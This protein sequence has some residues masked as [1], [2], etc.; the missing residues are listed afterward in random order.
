M[1]VNNNT[2]TLEMKPI[3][4]KKGVNLLSV[5]PLD[6]IFTPKPVVS[7]LSLSGI[8]GKAGVGKGSGMT[9]LNMRQNIEDAFNVSKAQAVCLLIDSP[10]GS[11]VQ[12]EMIASRIIELS[13]E[14]E[15]P[16][17]SFV[18][19]IA[20][21]GGYWLA[22]AG[23]EI[24]ASKSSIVGSIGVISAGFGFTDAIA[25]LGIERRV[26]SQGKNK[27]VLD[28]FKPTQKKDVEIINKL[29]KQV[30]QHFIDHVKT[31]RPGKLTQDDNILFNGDFWSGEIA[32]DFGLIDGIGNMYQVMKERFGPKVKFEYITAKES[33]LK[34]RLGLNR[35]QTDFSS[36]FAANLSEE[37]FQQ[38]DT[39]YDIQKYKLW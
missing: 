10:G 6:K 33:W 38:I 17:Y 12:S 8:I 7:V 37:L 2:A 20:A 19:D 21:S 5:W 36:E 29:Q 4:N 15:I 25:K 39:R 11:P 28:P 18:Q 31:R 26:I 9:F 32:R 22:C 30:H 16:V 24:Y 34:K 14:K 1:T 3:E 13:K 27:S 35:E 23:E